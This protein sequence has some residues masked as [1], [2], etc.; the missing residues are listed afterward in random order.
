L[1]NA[2]WA[3]EAEAGPQVA[4]F[5]QNFADAEDD[6]IH[7]WKGIYVWTKLSIALLLNN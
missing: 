3:F 7:Y 4:Q 2:F 1:K 5:C 6:Y